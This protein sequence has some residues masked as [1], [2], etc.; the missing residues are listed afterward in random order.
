MDPAFHKDRLDNIFKK[1]ETDP[2]KQGGTGLGLAIVKSF[3]EA[4]GGTVTVETMEGVGTT[5]RFTLPGA[6][7]RQEQFGPDF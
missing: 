1:L 7:I 4:Q 3:V 5:F 2:Q 6:G